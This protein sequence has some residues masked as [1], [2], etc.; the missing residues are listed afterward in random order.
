MSLYEDDALPGKLAA[1]LAGELSAAEREALEKHLAENP[2]SEKLHQQMRLIWQQ[3]SAP[4]FDSQRA[5]HKLTERIRAEG[6][7]PHDSSAEPDE[8]PVRV[9]RLTPWLRWAAAIALPLVAVAAFFY[10]QTRPAQ[11]V[12]PQAS[13][14]EKAIPVGQKSFLT[15]PDGSK[16]WL[17]ADSK[18]KYPKVFAGST[19]EVY[20]EGEAFFDVVKNPKQPF[21]IR[22]AQAQIQVLGTSFDVKAYPDSKTVETVVVTGKVKV[23]DPANDKNFVLLQPNEKGVYRAESRK[24]T[25]AT[26]AQQEEKAEYVDWKTGTLAFHDESLP[27][28]AAKLER[29]YG[30]KV[31][32]DEAALASCRVTARFDNNQPIDKVLDYIRMVTPIEYTQDGTAIKL[33]GKGCD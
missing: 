29:W 30:V 6:L 28:I 25:K 18:L 27:E 31:E 2:E 17:N 15:L 12:A 5:F 16:V 11:S 9:L 4:A 19:R 8:T 26:V 14:L 1:Y 33:H 13:L 32:A 21:V 3:K 24:I 7:L 23:S 10:M 20:L 22:T